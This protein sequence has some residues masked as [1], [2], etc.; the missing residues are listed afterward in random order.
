[1]LHKTCERGLSQEVQHMLTGRG[2]RLGPCPWFNLAGWQAGQIPGTSYS[3]ETVEDLSKKAV[4]LA[5]CQCS[6]DLL[7]ILS[8]STY[9]E[10]TS[11][12]QPSTQLTAPTWWSQKSQ[13]TNQL[14]TD[15]PMTPVVGISPHTPCHEWPL[16][17]SPLLLVFLCLSSL[18][19]FSALFSL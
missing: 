19:H 11:W 7:V 5:A 12:P 9:W 18:G 13:T 14:V 1:M 17:R 3:L 4:R 8:S 2:I 16:S 10:Q 6:I 15:S